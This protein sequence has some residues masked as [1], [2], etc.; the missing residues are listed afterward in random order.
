MSTRNRVGPHPSPS[1]AGGG[2][3]RN[4][5]RTVAVAMVTA[6][7]CLASLGVG[8]P[9]HASVA[10]DFSFVGHRGYP[11]GRY[12]E[13]TIPSFENAYRHG[14]PA[15]ETDIRL[16]ADDRFVVMHDQ[17]LRRTTTC[18][19]AVDRRTLHWIQR[20][21]RGQ[22]G[23]ERIPGLSDYVSWAASHDM[24]IVIEIKVDPLNRW[25]PNDFARIDR[26][27][28][29]EGMAGRVHLLSFSAPLLEM[30]K[31]VDTAFFTDW[32]VPAGADLTRVEQVDTWTSSVSVLSAALDDTNVAQL[33]A[34]GVE[35]FGRDT[36][37]KS[38]WAHLEA[39]GADGL[40]VDDPP[41]YETWE[42]SSSGG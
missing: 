8:S 1:S 38:D 15:V 27:I 16:T 41:G 23:H 11:A 13:N 24:N 30:A 10:G 9:A 28:N 42:S 25:T 29:R 26:L 35:V 18:R 14:A 36:D 20:R 32:I 6:A 19:G 31:G 33:H 2:R 40:L 4:V 21:C 3:G 34:E 5:R 22:V 17:F 12:T 37:L 39:V 7:S